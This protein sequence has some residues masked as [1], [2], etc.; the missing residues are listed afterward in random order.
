MTTKTTLNTSDIQALLN[1]S[2]RTA[3]RIK[4][5]VIDYSISKGR[6]PISARKCLAN[7]FAE[8]YGINIALIDVLLQ[9]K[10]PKSQ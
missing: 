2:E 3:R 8:L 4:K 10:A 1:T 7:D 6:I 9:K 5:R